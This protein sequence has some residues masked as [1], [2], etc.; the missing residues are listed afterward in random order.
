MSVYH[1]PIAKSN[2][3]GALDM[4]VTR[5]DA[6]RALAVAPLAVGLAGCSESSA[7]T[8][9]EARYVRLPSGILQPVSEAILPVRQDAVP[10]S[11]IS[12]GWTLALDEE[13][14]IGPAGHEAFDLDGVIGTPVV[15]MFDGWAIGSFQSGVIRGAVAPPLEAPLINE[16]WTSPQGRSGYLGLGGRLVE[17]YSDLTLPGM[18]RVTAQYFHLDQINFRT[19]TYITPERATPRRSLTTGE[20]IPIWYP[21]GIVQP[22]A[23]LIKIAKR[24]RAG[25]IIGWIGDTGINFGYSDDFDP[26]T[27]EVR[28]RNRDELPSW[29]PPQV[30]VQCYVGRD[31]D[32]PDFKGDLKS[33]G[34][35]VN[36]FDAFGRYD[37]M[38]GQ[39]GTEFQPG[40]YTMFQRDHRG[41]LIAS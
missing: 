41:V 6:L 3:K 19:V 26:L 25:D 10:V 21:G 1:R 22:Q 16:D 20:E 28:Q 5:R 9:R 2:Q 14:I 29:D 37:G 32:R 23:E 8:V 17:V 33:G 18:G 27:G 35:K 39:L 15:A 12:G 38:T 7:N 40:E 31:F 30:H 13:A 34:K 11:R 24:V 36:I 4:P